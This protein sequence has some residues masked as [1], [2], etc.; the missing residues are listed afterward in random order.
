MKISDWE[1]KDGLRQR[2]LEYS[3]VLNNSI[4]VKHCKNVEEQ[5]SDKP[6]GIILRIFSF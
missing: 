1:I 6:V 5:V 3:V 4:G 2:K